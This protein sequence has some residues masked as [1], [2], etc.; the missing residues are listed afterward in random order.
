MALGQHIVLRL[1]DNRVIAPCAE[2]RRWVARAVLELARGDELLAFGLA[3]THLHLVAA[4]AREA[5]GQLARRVEISL[6]QRLSLDVGFVAAYLKPVDEGRHLYRAFT[7]VLEQNTHHGLSWDPLHEA[8]NLPDL[9]G[10][11]LLGIYTAATVRRRLPRVTRNDLLSCMGIDELQPLE[12]PAE[13]VPAAA[14]AAAGLTSLN[15][16]SRETV[17]ARRAMV[18]LLRHLPPAELSARLGVTV[19]TLRDLR[20]APADPRLVQAIRLQLGLMQHRTEA[21]RGQQLPFEKPRSAI[22]CQAKSH[23]LVA[24]CG[25]A[26]TEPSA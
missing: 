20:R 26:S 3:D 13:L 11:R 15:G 24:A 5:A 21:L 18:Y 10:M 9:L 22:P 6:V 8:S 7:Y 23:A 25:T 4:C 19:R 16:K 17:G 1:V 14:R 2:K 12:G